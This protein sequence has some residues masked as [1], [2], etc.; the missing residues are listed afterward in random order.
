MFQARLHN[1]PNF[2]V[3]RGEDPSRL[4]IVFSGKR[5]GLHMNRFDFL[6]LTGLLKH[7]RIL[8][9]D[10]WHAWYQRGISDRVSDF[11]AIVEALREQIAELAP[12]RVTVIGNSMGGFAAIL[13][14]HLL[15]ADDVH[16]IGPQTC[17]HFFRAARVLDALI[18]RCGLDMLKLLALRSRQSHLFDLTRVLD[19]YNGKTRYFVHVC[20]D[21]MDARRARPLA[22]RAGVTFLKYPG[23]SHN[24]VLAM[25]KT[26]FLSRVFRLDGHEAVRDL[27]AKLYSKPRV[28]RVAAE[29]VRESQ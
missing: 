29:A 26:G 2:F 15:G 8:L 3:E 25:A 4:I 1:D 11:P 17:I 27:H 7:S 6:D 16:A 22:M 28:R 19:R 13:A 24:V 18:V 12:T 5:G 21:S 10:P 9:C 20:A 23:D 14:G